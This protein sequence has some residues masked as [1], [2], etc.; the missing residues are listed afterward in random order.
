MSRFSRDHVDPRNYLNAASAQITAQQVAHAYDPRSSQNASP[1]TT[2][3]RCSVSRR[4]ALQPDVVF[5]VTL[6][7]EI[8]RHL[9][10][11][12]YSL[13][14]KH[15]GI[16]LASAKRT[17]TVIHEICGNIFAR[18]VKCSV[19][20]DRVKHCWPLGFIVIVTGKLEKMKIKEENHY[21]KRSVEYFGNINNY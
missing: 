5:F 11:N 20:Y 13:F 18:G 2:L 17:L 8:L 19:R 4:A 1:E 6:F 9:Y 12:H 14:Y 15:I 3:D 7:R 10:S 16:F 21:A